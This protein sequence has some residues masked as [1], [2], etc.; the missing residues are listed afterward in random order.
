MT[1]SNLSRNHISVL[2]VED[3]T[4]SRELVRRVL[5]NHGNSVHYEVS[6][7][8][9]LASARQ[10]LLEQKF[11]NV[12]LDLHLPDSSGL[13]TLHSIREVN[14]DV[15][16]IVLS[17]ITDHETAI[18]SIKHGADYYI[19]KGDM[20]R[21]M[22]SRS[23]CYSVERSRRKLNTGGQ[24]Q[25]QSHVDQLRYQ[26]RE[27]K[28]S[29]SDQIH[30]K[31]N[32]ELSMQKLSEEHEILLDVLPAMI[33]H[34][35]VN[36][37]IVRLNKP[38]ADL[39]DL[40][41]NDVIGKDF[42]RVFAGNGDHLRTKHQNILKDRIASDENTEAYKSSRGSLQYHMT[43]T[44]PHLDK[45]GNIS[46]LVIMAKKTISEIKPDRSVGL[47]K[48]LRE[49]FP[50]DNTFMSRQSG[51]VRVEKNNRPQK[52]YS[53]KVLIVD[54]DSLNRILIGA[55]LKGS[56]LDFDFAVSGPEAIE[57]SL[58][59]NFDMVMTALLMPG[60]DGLEVARKLREANFQSPILV[61]TSDYSD[62]TRQKIAEADC[63]DRIFKPIS[64]MD[65]FAA[66]DKFL[67][68]PVQ[69]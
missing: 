22:L 1:D 19:V 51:A 14:S 66:F 53:G 28:E 3:D 21:E 25:L 52:Q 17:G 39:V 2:L 65:I 13:D 12:I 43:E 31:N 67:L 33:W 4:A 58:S 24:G 61:M 55:H 29:L 10:M 7:A 9:D 40:N 20:L 32:T 63:E 27:V 59:E 15:P 64:K 60:M 36:G 54:D 50:I 23:I 11:D 56:G 37:I 57:K 48:T 45:N 5:Y 41:T 44:V 30:S 38:A 35:D 47:R 62:G 6:E 49:K 42:Y 26:I 68:S 8:K 34:I 16:I 18:N 69:A 46:G